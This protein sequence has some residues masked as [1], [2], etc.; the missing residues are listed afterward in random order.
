MRIAFIGTGNIARSHATGLVKMNGIEFVGAYDVLPERAQAF[1]AQ[2]GGE[3]VAGLDEML[4][5]TKPDAA[6]VCLPPYAHGAAEMALLD[7]RIP[8]L[9]EKPVSNSIVTARKILDRV[10]AT[11]T[12]TAVGYMNRYR[13]SAQRAKELLA[14]DPAVLLDGAWIGGTPGVPW[15][16]VQAQ[17]GGQI[18]E[19][20]TH[21]LDLVRYLVGEPQTVCGV[22]AHGFVR[23]MPGYDVS[24]ASAVSVRFAS[25]AVGS[26]LS[27]C[28]NRSSGGG[29]HLTIVAVHHVTRFSGWD[30]ASVITKSRLE[31]E[32]ITGEP[33]VFE[34]EDAAFVQ[35]V[36]S[37]DRA[38]VRS[39]Y[40]D[41]LKTL[42]FSLA[43]TKAL[44][45]DAPVDVSS[46]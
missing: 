5:R 7:R 13:R 8:F 4:D 30:L 45:V 29:V 20:T 39:P 18:V 34:L 36:Q 22:G 42:A 32:R 11:G 19:Q 10:L 24:D 38:L 17:S 26:L 37:G 27:C 31:E 25:G 43:A 40:E 44:Q 16:R 46:I 12:L 14:D 1:A 6:W 9:V 35:A 33:N 28:A 23:D 15:W 21:V 41:G 3:A 2:F